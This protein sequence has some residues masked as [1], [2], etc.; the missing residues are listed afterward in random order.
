MASVDSIGQLW[1]IHIP[2]SVGS[3]PIDR[4][5]VGLGWRKMGD[6]TQIPPNREAFKNR[7]QSAYPDAKPGAIPVWAGVLYR[8]VH[9]MSVGDGIVYPS[10]T[11]RM[12]NLGMVTGPCEYHPVAAHEETLCRRPVA[13]R[14]HIPRSSFSQAALYEIGSA[15]TL[16]QVANNADEFLGAFSG[17]APQETVVDDAGA[18][19]VSEQVAQN[20]DDYVLKRLKTAMTDEEFEHFVAG[21]LTAMGYF[22]RVTR[23]SGDGGVDVI[24]HKDELGF[25]PPI[26]KVQCKQILATIGRPDVQRL[27]GAVQHGEFGLFV[28]LGAYSNDALTYE[29]MKPNLRL[30]SGRELAELVYRHYHLFPPSMQRQVPLR[31]I[32]VPG[33]SGSE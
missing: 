31:R 8:F 5:F 25:E 20:S 23:K 12:I 11:D 32:Y 19:V 18:E 16:F 28:T 9:E 30:I 33:P 21:L 14:A 29:A 26:I 13:W 4:G 27:D 17:H 10:K 2:A 1:G 15:L 7:V 22:A 3:E 24:A 6:I